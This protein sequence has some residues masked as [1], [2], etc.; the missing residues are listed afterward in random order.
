LDIGIFFPV[1]VAFLVGYMHADF[2]VGSAPGLSVFEP[3]SV[4]QS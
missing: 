2:L 3:T 1:L 4:V